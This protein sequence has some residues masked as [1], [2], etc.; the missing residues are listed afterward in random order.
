METQAPSARVKL[1]MELST[2]LAEKITALREPLGISQSAAIRHLLV[3]GIAA[4]TD[5]H[6][7]SLASA[8][9][10]GSKAGDR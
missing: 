3:L 7:G 4:V 2:D 8:I 10:S 6:A 5:D 9:E 1:N